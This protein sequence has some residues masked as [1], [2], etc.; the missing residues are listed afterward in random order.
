M[1]CRS[2]DSCRKLFIKLKILP[3]SSLYILSLLHFVVNNEELFTKN[4]EIQDICTRKHLNLYQPSATL[5]KYQKGVHYMGIKIFN[6]LPV[7]IK[8]VSDNPKKF[9]S[10]LKKFLSILFILWKNCIDC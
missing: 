6:T 10:N 4:N 1:G 7:H 9:D 3:L 8:Q 2:R 5:S